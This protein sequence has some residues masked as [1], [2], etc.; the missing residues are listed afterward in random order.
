M[1]M[2]PNPSTN[3]FAVGMAEAAPCAKARTKVAIIGPEATPPASNAMPTNTGLHQNDKN[4]AKAKPGS[5]KYHNF[6]SGTVMRTMES[7]IAM[8]APKESVRRMSPR[9]MVPPVTSSICTP[10]TCTAGSMR[11]TIRP[12]RNPTA[13]RSLVSIE[14]ICIP[15]TLPISMKPACTPSRNNTRPI[16][17]SNRPLIIPRISFRFSLNLNPLYTKNKSVIGR[18]AIRDSLNVAGI[19]SRIGAITPTEGIN[20]LASP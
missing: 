13:I 1:A 14:A 3:T 18:S 7:E 16:S 15:I 4:K 20:T 11:T 6:T 12:K 19:L 9:G 2:T 10:R 5:R 8:A 17:T